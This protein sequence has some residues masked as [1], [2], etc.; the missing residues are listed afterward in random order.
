MRCPKCDAELADGQK[1]CVL[2][3]AFTPASGYF[4]SDKKELHLTKPM[5]IALYS[6]I[7]MLVIIAGYLLLRITPPD[8]ITQRWIDDLCQRRIIDAK[9]MVTDDFNTSLEERF[10]DLRE[11]SD[12]LYMD[13]SSGNPVISVSD[14]IIPDDA[15]PNISNVQVVIQ[16]SSGQS[17]RQ[18]NVELFKAGRHWKINQILSGL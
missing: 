14:P 7:G 2:C 1:V 16:D 15:N 13:T 3:G 10:T 11:M 18:I 5:R 9:K 4:Y 17:I 6:I 12:N 8:V